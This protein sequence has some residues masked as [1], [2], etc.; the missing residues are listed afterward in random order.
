MVV[1]RVDGYG[2]YLF[3]LLKFV[4]GVGIGAVGV[5]ADEC[6]AV[7]RQYFGAGWWRLVGFCNRC[8]WWV[9]RL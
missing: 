5:V 9:V 2:A 6:C 7:C 3:L 4:V 1:V 8:G